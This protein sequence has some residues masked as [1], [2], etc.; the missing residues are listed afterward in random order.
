[1]ATYT[2]L[3]NLAKENPYKIHPDSDLE[4]LHVEDYY[5]GTGSGIGSPGSPNYPFDDEALANIENMMES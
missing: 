3:E 2:W 1:M 4:D 5:K